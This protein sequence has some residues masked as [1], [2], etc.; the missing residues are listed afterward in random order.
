MHP[1]F[2]IPNP[3]DYGLSKWGF[4]P[5]ETPLERL[6]DD[7][8]APWEDLVSDLPLL[9]HGGLQ[10]QIDR[11]PVLCTSRLGDVREW[12]RAY[13]CLT[14]LLHGYMWG[15][16][17]RTV[18]RTSGYVLTYIFFLTRSEYPPLHL[19]PLIRCLRVS[20]APAHRHFRCRLSMELHPQ[21]R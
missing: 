19:H 16:E 8:Y 7:H 12:R 4:L 15:G 6:P 3:S 5:S 17:P 10:D 9:H 1:S 21:P 2:P 20:A 14:F 11:L 13:V 18:S